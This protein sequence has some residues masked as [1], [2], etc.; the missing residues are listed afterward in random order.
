G[1][2]VLFFECL[3]DDPDLSPDPLIREQ[4]AARLKFYE[5]FGARPITG[6]AYETPL[7]PD[8]TDPPYLMADTLGA[9]KAP[10][11]ALVRK[12]IRAILERKY[13]DICPPEYVNMV[14]DSV[15]DDPVRLR[16]FRYVR[17]RAQ[18][19]LEIPERQTLIPVVVNDQHDIHHMHDRGY[20]EAPARVRAIWR[21]LE[22]AG[23]A[24]RV[25]PQH[26]SDRHIL[27]V[28]DAR[29]VSYIRRACRI[30]GSK[31][32]I[33]PYVFPVRNAAR[34]PKEQTVL[35]GYYCI[36][37]FTPLN[38]N[39][40]LAA[41]RAVDCT[42][43]ATDL[44]LDGAPAAYA[45]VRP[46]GHHAESKVFG[47]FC[48]FSNAAIAANYLSRYGRVAILDIDYHHGNGQQDIFYQRSDVLTVS[49]HGDP[50]F[51]YPYFS[52]FRDEKGLGEGAGY[53]INFPLP[54]TILP[55]QYHKVLG[56]ALERIR[57]FEPAYLVVP[58]GFDTAKGDPTGTWS[59]LAKDFVKI[60]QAIGTEGYPTL[61]VQEGGYRV[62]TLGTNV[63]SFLTG[64]IKGQA[65]ANMPPREKIEH[66]TASYD[67]EA[68]AWRDAVTVEDVSRVRSL[69]GITGYFT[70]DEIAIAAELVDERLNKG[71]R[72]GYEFLLAEQ[73]GRLLGYAC[74]GKIDGTEGSFDLYWIAVDPEMQGKGLGR[75]IREKTEKAMREMGAI[76]VYADTSSSDKYGPTRAFYIS[77]GFHEQARLDD[78][79]RKGDGKVIFEKLLR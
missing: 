5:R 58:A 57:R 54:E 59:N 6:T 29:L 38:E 1:A 27:E 60:G 36:D 34:P 47:G 48:Y 16:E 21:E 8:A 9:D 33:Y 2:D 7:S 28:H 20:V 39:A 72:S 32:S 55:D 53:N 75:L 62:R 23:I 79:Y 17:R 12:S 31:T 25:P 45:L 46:P 63:R 65:A 49:I 73:D 3:P 51:A 4:N 10:G 77:S 68:I 78:F 74:F 13:G 24:R 35:A 56:K 52:G 44:I 11:R 70:A 19:R 67:I 26:H 41:R 71:R 64:L 69:V 40:W 15:T 42:M 66:A 76:S 22:N 30:A 50:S 43:T 18:R 37:T 14:V 61:I